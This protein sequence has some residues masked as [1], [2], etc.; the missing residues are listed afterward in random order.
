MKVSIRNL[1]LSTII[2]FLTVATAQSGDAPVYVFTGEATNDTFGVSVAS[3]GDVN[4]DGFDDLIVGAMWNKAGGSS[5]GRAYV[6]S[7]LN[8]DT[9]YVFSGETTN[10][11]L[12]MSVASAGDVNNDGFDDLIVGAWLGEATAD[13]TGRVYVFSGRTG[14]KIYTFNAE[15][16]HDHF[17]HSVASA[18]DVNNDGF[19]DLII[20][21]RRNDAGGAD[22]GRAYVFSGL[23]ADTLHVFTGEAIDDRFGWS[24]ASA[25]DV[26]NDGFADLI[27]GAPSN[28]ASARAAGRAYVFSGRTGDTLYVFTGKSVTDWFGGSVASAGD[29]NNDGYD[30]LIVGAHQSSEGGTFTGR[31]YVFSGQTGDTLYVFSGETTNERLGISVAS[32]GDVNDDGFDDLIV[33]ARLNSAGGLYAGRAYVFSGQSG[34]KF[35][36]F[37]GEASSDFF[38]WSVAS[39]GDVNNDGFDDL[40]VGARS[41]DV[42]GSNAGRA[43]VY[44]G[45]RFVCAD[46]NGDSLVNVD[47]VSFL[48]NFYF[49]GG[50]TPYPCGASDLNC[51]GSVDI[52]DITYLA[53][54]LNGTGAPPCC[55][56]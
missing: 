15:A 46:A 13:A 3:A 18:G 2:L 37:H 47:D 38:G 28:D 26:D 50:A 29:V 8:G 5:A 41:N 36:F 11:G 19:D 48:M 55:A 1:L 6:F 22:A 35:H 53:A 45:A 10:E 16:A 25:G 51:D 31:A 4:G 54:Y 42:G 30:D 33:G 44:L 34:N 49:Y 43:Y 21:A 9:L 14:E 39:A 12:G 20:G 32:A 56:E 40:I 23:N 17:G 7:G 27:V 52:A 24:V